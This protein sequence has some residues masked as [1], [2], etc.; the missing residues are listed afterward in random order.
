MPVEDDEGQYV[1]SCYRGLHYQQ[2]R[3]FQQQDIR[4]RQPDRLKGKINCFNAIRERA[5]ISRTWSASTNTLGIVT[6]LQQTMDTTNGELE[7]RLCRPRLRL[8]IGGAARF[9]GSGFARFACQGDLYLVLKLFLSTRNIPL[10]LYEGIV[11]YKMPP[12]VTTVAARTILIS[13]IQVIQESEMDGGSLS[14][15][16]LIN[17]ISA[18]IDVYLDH[19]TGRVSIFFYCSLHPSKC[20][21]FLH[22]Q[23]GSISLVVQNTCGAL[24]MEAARD[25]R[26]PT[27][28]KEEICHYRH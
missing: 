18:L 13:Y 6:L 17:K 15:R 5:K 26:L 2:A 7:T 22:G 19:V 21:Y 27:T 16:K 12:R 10:P 1:V 23:S 25:C 11:S 8:A 24:F 20:P 28:L 9:T 4:E 3:G 14:S